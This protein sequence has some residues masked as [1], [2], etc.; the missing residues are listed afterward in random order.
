[1]SHLGFV[2]LG[3]CAMNVQ[4]VQG[5]IYQ[6]LNHGVSTGALFMIVGM[7]SDRRHTR[8]IA[9]Y[10]GLKHVMPKFVAAFLIITLSSIGMPGLNGF[11]GEFLTILG[12]FRWRPEFAVVRRDRRHPL[13][14]L[15]AVD[16]PAR[17]LRRG[18][19]PEEQATCPTSPPREWAA[20]GP[21]RGHGHRDGRVAE[22]VFLAPMEPS[23]EAVLKR[24][25]RRRA[26]AGRRTGRRQG[27]PG[28]PTRT[29]TPRPTD[30]HGMPVPVTP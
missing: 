16:V 23:V 29:A 10:G 7:L 27:T 12:A 11:V 30:G 22:R 28:V 2:V 21:T 18:D 9:E 5:A 6:M 19:Q 20:L 26:R 15:H 1:M 3:I 4:G 17:E 14:G 13:G 25:T 24:V 8:L